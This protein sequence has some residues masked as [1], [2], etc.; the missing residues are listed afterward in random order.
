[1]LSLNMEVVMSHTC[2]RF[3]SA[4]LTLLLLL[5]ILASSGCVGLASQLMYWA[6]GGHKID[7][8]FEGLEGKTVAIVCVA[9]NGESSPHSIASLV[10]RS[11]GVILKEKGEKIDVIHQDDIADW[12]DNNDWNQ[13]DYREIGRGVGADLVLA[14]DLDGLRL[15]E[16]S[17]LYRGKADVAV[18]VYDLTKDGEVVFRREIPEY[19]F[20]KNGPRHA[21]EM[22]EARFRRL[23]A[24]ML[25]QQVAKYFYNYNIEEGFA[26]D[27]LMLG[28]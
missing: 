23:F 18:T 17:T 10:E 5:P 8:E 27:A 16:G 25:S 13:I 15:Y 24:Q 7:A 26:S 1:M 21:T 14:V 3:R 20:P 4:T 6:K 2:I 12:I 28:D 9:A 19:S 11:I 22:S